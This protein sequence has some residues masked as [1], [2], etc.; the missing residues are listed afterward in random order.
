MKRRSKVCIDRRLILVILFIVILVTL[1]QFTR[2]SDTRKQW[3]SIPV[4]DSQLLGVLNNLGSFSYLV[5][6]G[7]L[8]D[9]LI[10]SAT[11]DWFDRN[12]FNWTRCSPHDTVENL[13][14]QGNGVFIEKYSGGIKT[15][16]ECMKRAKRVIVLPS[17]Y[18]NIPSLIEILDSRFTLFCRE[19][20][21]YNYL[22]KQNTTAQI[23]LDHDM[24]FRATK[25]LLTKRIIPPPDFKAR[26]EK[27]EKRIQSLP[28]DVRFF[29]KDCEKVGNRTTDMDL[30]G[31]LGGFLWNDCREKIDYGAQTLL[32]VMYQFDTVTTDRLHVGIAAALTGRKVFLYDNYYGKIAAVYHRTL[33]RLSNAQYIESG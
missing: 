33:Y 26:V 1:I 8:G 27:V 25:H 16:M 31:S 18:Y 3:L 2:S 22:M 14:Y 23:L 11:M 12:H 19:Q 30:S 28:K 6:T 29:R 10:G 13:V 17:T 24:A 32:K 5:N 15:V 20:P 7:N 9:S 21:S 4:D